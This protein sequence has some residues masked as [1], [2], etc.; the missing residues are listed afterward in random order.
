MQLDNFEL[1]SGVSKQLVPVRCDAQHCTLVNTM[2]IVILHMELLLFVVFHGQPRPRSRIDFSGNF[3][4][5]GAFLSRGMPAVH[6]THPEVL[7]LTEM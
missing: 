3:S 5:W 6:R 4:P 2:H 7:I 1:L